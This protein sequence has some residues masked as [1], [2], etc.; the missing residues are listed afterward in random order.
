MTP[1]VDAMLNPGGSEPD[2]TTYVTGAVNPKTVGEAEKAVP[3]T[4]P[5][6]V[7]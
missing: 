4:N 1:V 2:E 3:A 5:E 7:A 6:N